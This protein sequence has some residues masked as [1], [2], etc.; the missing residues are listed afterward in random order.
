[1][2][3]TLEVQVVSAKLEH[4]C[5]TVHAGFPSFF[6]LGMEHGDVPTLKLPLQTTCL[7]IGDPSRGRC[8]TKAALLYFGSILELLYFEIKVSSTNIRLRYI[9]R[10][11]IP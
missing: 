5:S 11:M 1:M 8:F 10:Y 3:G 6:G 7:Q 9:W 2:L 4:G